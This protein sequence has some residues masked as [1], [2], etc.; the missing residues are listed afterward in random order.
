MPA[1]TGRPWSGPAPPRPRR[2]RR[3]Y[4]GWWASETQ[5][6][7]FLACAVAA[8]RT[9]RLELGTAIA[10]AFARNPMS[11]AVAANDLQ[12]LSAGR[13]VLGLGSQ[14]KPHITQALL[15]AVVAAGC[16]DARVRARDPRD[17]GELGRRARRLTSAASSTRT[18]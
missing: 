1:D 11:V 18:R 6:D 12:A 13:F 8:E 5:I 2:R 17:L 4:D 15:D 16:A 14:V 7:P 10:V 9:E 3:G